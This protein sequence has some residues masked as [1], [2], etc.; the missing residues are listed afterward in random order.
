MDVL[1]SYLEEEEPDAQET[2]RVVE[3]AG[4]RRFGYRATSGRRP[5]ARISCKRPWTSSGCIDV[6]VN[7]AAYQMV[8]PGGIADIST[9]QFDRVLKTNLYAMFWLSKAAIPHMPTRREHHQHNLDR[10]LPT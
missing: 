4:G 6:L 3:E 10:G 1:I 2:A 9:E 8:Q 7:N 5:T